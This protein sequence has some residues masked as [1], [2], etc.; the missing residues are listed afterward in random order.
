MALPRYETSPFS[1]VMY[2][3]GTCF[4]SLPNITSVIE[5]EDVSAF[6][7]AVLELCSEKCSKTQILQYACEFGVTKEQATDLIELLISYEL[8]SKSNEGGK[9]ARILENKP[10]LYNVCRYL[11]ISENLH[12]LDYAQADT[13]ATDKAL[14]E[15]YLKGHD[16][17]SISLQ[18]NS[19]TTIQLSHPAWRQNTN[20]TSTVSHWLYWIAGRLCQTSFLDSLPVCLKAVPSKGSRHPIELYFFDEHGIFFDKGYYHYNS[21]YHRLE[22][23]EEN[24]L[25]SEITARDNSALVFVSLVYERYQWR[26]RHSWSYKDLFHEIG[27]FIENMKEVACQLGLSI[28]HTPIPSH[29]FLFQDL[30]EEC[31]GCFSLRTIHT[32]CLS[33]QT[34]EQ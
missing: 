6:I 18:F 13:F 34:F 23:L 10:D 4:L 16:Y 20:P 5:L 25:A 19:E 28:E 9:W 7:W 30:V 15:S 27:H 21:E 8:L 24:Q 1:S 22:L 11:S 12:R 3:E 14:M 2:H 26:Y 33:Q 31:V 32:Q 29:Q 17:P